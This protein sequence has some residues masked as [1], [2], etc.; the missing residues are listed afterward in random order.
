ME[1]KTVD[2]IY[3]CYLGKHVGLRTASIIE[4]VSVH[5]GRGF[6]T[7]YSTDTDSILDF[8]RK[9]DEKDLW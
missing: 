1:K 5:E 2:W 7:K 4:F 9:V 8:I 6:F 3:R